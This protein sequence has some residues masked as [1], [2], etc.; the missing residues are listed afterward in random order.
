MVDFTDKQEINLAFYK[1]HLEEFLS[2]NL[3]KG[4][5]VVISDEKIQGAF[6]TLEVAI[7][8]AVDHFQVGDYILQQI[9]NED[10]IVSFLKAAIA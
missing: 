5:Y 1:S 7:S 6:D 3:L 10:D 8:Y 2:N 4:K 9:I